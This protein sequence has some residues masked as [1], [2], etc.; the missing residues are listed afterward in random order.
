MI[1]KHFFNTRVMEGLHWSLR[2]EK[3]KFSPDAQAQVKTMQAPFS[4]VVIKLCREMP[5][6]RENQ[7]STVSF[8]RFSNSPILQNL[9]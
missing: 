5:S 3:V 6:L 8:S 7:L 4:T 1:M 9:S 2:M